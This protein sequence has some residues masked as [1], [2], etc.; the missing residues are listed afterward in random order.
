M[1]SITYAHLHSIRRYLGRLSPIAWQEQEELAHLIDTLDAV[2]H[3]KV[4]PVDRE[5]NNNVPEGNPRDKS[6]AA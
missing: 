2:L 3:R 4:V 5:R 6:V 1:A